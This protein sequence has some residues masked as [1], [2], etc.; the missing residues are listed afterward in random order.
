MPAPACRHHWQLTARDGRDGKRIDALFAR[1]DKPVQLDFD[2]GRVSISNTCN[3]M[4]G[5]Y[6]AGSGQADRRPDWRRP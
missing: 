5:G 4:G 3:R 6:T 1:A 2:D